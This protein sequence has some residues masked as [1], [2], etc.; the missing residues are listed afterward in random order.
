MGTPDPGDA[1]LD[2][3]RRQDAVSALG[4]DWPDIGGVLDKVAE[5]LEEVREALREGEREKAAE[6]LGDLLL[7]SV[8]LSRFLNADPARRLADATDRL[9]AR[10][11]Q[12]RVLA[13]SRGKDL[14]SCT[15]EELDQLWREVKSRGG[16]G[17]KNVLDIGGADDANSVF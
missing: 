9:C 1:L 7:A 15:P 10:V 11:E 14:R 17:L 3:R 16:K 6:E 13:E 2:S 4:F 12:A 5:E 8:N